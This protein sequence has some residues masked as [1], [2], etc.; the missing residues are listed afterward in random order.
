MTKQSSSP[1]RGTKPAHLLAATLLA[2]PLLA[3]S[4]LLAAC[5]DDDE[6]EAPIPQDLV[7]DA[8]R[9]QDVIASDPAITALE[10]AEDAVADDRPVRAADLLLAGGIPAAG[11]QVE[12]VRAVT[13]GT[14]EGRAL[15]RRA[16]A[17]YEARVE[18]LGQYRLALERGVVEDMTLVEALRAQ[19]EADEAILAVDEALADIRPLAGPEERRP[20]VG[21]GGGRGPPQPGR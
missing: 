10:E 1:G 20:R 9:L 11:R 21:P 3:A 19:R 6:G 18:A 13:L 5:G 17:A 8:R 16:V 7:E 15:Q 4:A 14:D 12:R 2:A